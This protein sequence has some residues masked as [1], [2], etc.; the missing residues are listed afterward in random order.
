MKNLVYI[1]VLF[2]ALTFS[3]Q[4]QIPQVK[5]KDIS[6]KTVDIGQIS[7]NQKPIILSFFAT[8]C[9]P[10]LRELNAINEVYEEWQEE[11]GVQ[12]IA[13]S[14]DEGSDSLKVKPLARTQGW[15][16][17][18]WLDSNKELMRAFNVSM[19]PT[20]LIIHN[21]NIVYRHTG[22]VEGSE[23]ELIQQVRKLMQ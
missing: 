15:S 14:I 7:C 3:A 13:I 4:A 21:D 10:C 23:Q 17:S 12:F 18:V 20:I 6:G 9:K 5:L 1:I 22:Y 16:F 19:V 8:W 2:C 11:T